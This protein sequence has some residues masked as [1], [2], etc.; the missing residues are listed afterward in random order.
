MDYTAIEV[1][2]YNYQIVIFLGARSDLSLQLS[3][4]GYGVK[5]TGFITGI[6]N[7]T[8]FISL[9][10]GL[11]FIILLFLVVDSESECVERL[12]RIAEDDPVLRQNIADG[13]LSFITS[14]LSNVSKQVN[15]IV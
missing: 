1:A 12:K 7:H 5:L 13:R 2:C 9:Q 10:S 11:V 15:A 8:L 6:I 4:N 3:K 14:D